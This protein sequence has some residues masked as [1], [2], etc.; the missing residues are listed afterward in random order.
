MYVARL[1][2]EPRV[3]AI[4]Y[5]RGYTALHCACFFVKGQLVN[6]QVSATL[7]QHLL[8]AGAHP[9]ITNNSILLAKPYAARLALAAC[10]DCSPDG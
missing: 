3:R 9:S 1:L 7:V 4:D 5:P 8:Q 2:R 6:D 10:G